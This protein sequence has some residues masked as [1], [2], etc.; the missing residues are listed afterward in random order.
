MDRDE[1]LEA[2]SRVV[3]RSITRFGQLHP[4]EVEAI[5]KEWVKATAVTAALPLLSEPTG[6]A[7][8]EVRAD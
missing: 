1:L 2:V 4:T 5:C 6:K 3:G 8:E 7:K